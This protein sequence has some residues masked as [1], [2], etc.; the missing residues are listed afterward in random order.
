M[1]LGIGCS[2]RRPPEFEIL[3]KM[4]Y[5]FNAVGAAYFEDVGPLAASKIILRG[6]VC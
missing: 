6:I 2:V 5:H 3:L 4:L 1:N